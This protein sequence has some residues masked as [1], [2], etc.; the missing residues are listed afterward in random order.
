MPP[1]AKPLVRSDVAV[2]AT[3]RYLFVEGVLRL[4]KERFQ[5]ME[6]C[7][8]YD[9]FVLW[10]VEA[11]RRNHDPDGR[12][13]AH[14]GPAFLPWHRYMLM[15][16][17]S[18]LKRVLGADAGPDFGLPYWDW[19]SPFTPFTEDFLGEK[20]APGKEGPVADGP[21]AKSGAFPILFR[22]DKELNITRPDDGS[23]L[24]KRRLEP[25]NPRPTADSVRNALNF[26]AYDAP[27]WS[28]SQ[29]NSFRWALEHEH[30]QIHKWVG[31]MLGDIT[32]G[33]GAPNDPVF[34]LIHAN[35]DRVWTAWQRRHPKSRYQPA[36]GPGAL[37]GQRLKDELFA[38]VNDPPPP[39]IEDMLDVSRYYRYDP[40]GF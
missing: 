6:L 29:T 30:D 9:A 25:D 40:L 7:N 31:G 1:P 8:T 18:H 11:M 17:E 19:T 4:K 5:G 15:V 23:R 38:M 14:G 32:V 27:P 37:G 22:T 35:V 13:A 34:F 24:L 28:A 26:L 3:A 21:F 2:D 12:N 33:G 20:A 10:H 16:F 36:T 39:T